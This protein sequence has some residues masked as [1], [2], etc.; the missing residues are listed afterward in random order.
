MGLH[1]ASPDSSNHKID[2]NPRYLETIA[3]ALVKES[4]VGINRL[5]G[6]GDCGVAEGAKG[7]TNVMPVTTAKYSSYFTSWKT[8]SPFSLMP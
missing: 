5:R 2:A 1:P 3:N 4:D 6:A 7:K 8:F